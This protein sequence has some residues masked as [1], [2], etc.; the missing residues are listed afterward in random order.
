MAVLS[1]FFLLTWIS[2]TATGRALASP[3]IEAGVCAGYEVYAFVMEFV[4]L[5]KGR[6]RK[7]FFFHHLLCMFFCA[8]TAHAWVAIPATDVA[9]WLFVWRSI[10]FMLGGNFLANFRLV[11]SADGRSGQPPFYNHTR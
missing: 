11:V 7:D 3:G 2:C 9:H 6:F 8:A 10:C 4:Y 1:L 5:F